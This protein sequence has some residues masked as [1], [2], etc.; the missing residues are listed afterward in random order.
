MFTHYRVILLKPRFNEIEILFDFPILFNVNVLSGH[1][2]AR[3]LH[4]L[5]INVP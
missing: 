2:V 3:K 5:L 4:E 1:A